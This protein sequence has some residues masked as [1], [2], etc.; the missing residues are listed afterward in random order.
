MTQAIIQFAGN[1]R[2]VKV[3]QPGES[4]NFAT[5]MLWLTGWLNCSTPNSENCIS[6][7]SLYTT[8]SFDE[9]S[10]LSVDEKSVRRSLGGRKQ[11][12]FIF[13]R[14]CL[15]AE[16]SCEIASQI[17][18]HSGQQTNQKVC[19]SMKNRCEDNIFRALKPIESDWSVGEMFLKVVNCNKL[20]T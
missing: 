3:Q 18:E 6:R 4:C 11:Q 10:A 14:P 17:S 2:W 12:M 5:W 8:L 20:I 19:L 9:K 15:W 7:G 16:C 1:F 13:T